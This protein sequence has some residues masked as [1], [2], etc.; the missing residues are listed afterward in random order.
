MT[1]TKKNIYRPES[2]IEKDTIT[3]FGCGKFGDEKLV[4]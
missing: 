2:K 3:I 4:Y 1:E